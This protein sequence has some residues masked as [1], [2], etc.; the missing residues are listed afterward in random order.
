MK[1]KTIEQFIDDIAKH[2]PPHTKVEGSI[3][4]LEKIK[5]NKNECLFVWD[6]RLGEMVFKRGFINLLGFQNEDVNLEKFG[7]LFHPE[8]QEYIYRLGQAAIRHSIKHPELNSD[9]C[10]YVSHRIKKSN[11]DYIKIMAQSS[12]HSIDNQGLISSFLVKLSDISFVDT[13]DAVQYKFLANSL[14]DELF[15]DLVYDKNKSI[16]TP[17]ELEIIKEIQKG[18]SNFQIAENLRIS[19]FTVETHRKKIMKKSESHS[20]EELI[21]FCQR[22]GVL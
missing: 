12:P 17:R 14:D 19:K 16:F 10:L 13:T 1:T 21:L 4:D 15:H 11:G 5:F 3:N 22:N 18:M 8:D 20:A 6:L 2:Y 9:F 7:A